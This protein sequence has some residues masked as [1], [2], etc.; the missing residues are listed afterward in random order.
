[1]HRRWGVGGCK[2]GT[3]ILLTASSCG[4]VVG[5]EIEFENNW[6]EEGVNK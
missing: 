3:L 2:W 5:R 1:M 4:E 6:G